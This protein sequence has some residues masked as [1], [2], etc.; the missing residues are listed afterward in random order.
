MSRKCWP[1]CVE[2][3]FPRYVNMLS[4]ACW[5]SPLNFSSLQVHM[6]TLVDANGHEDRNLSWSL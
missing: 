6:K 1:V 4:A 5:T 3:V 2:R